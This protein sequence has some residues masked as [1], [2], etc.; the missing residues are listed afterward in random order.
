MSHH[1]VYVAP[2]VFLPPPTPISDPNFSPSSLSYKQI[3]QETIN[4]RSYS[5][6][7]TRLRLSWSDKTVLPSRFLIIYKDQNSNKLEMHSYLSDLCKWILN[8]S[9]LPDQSVIYLSGPMSDYH[10]DFISPDLRGKI[11]FYDCKNSSN[12][13]LI[14]ALPPPEVDLIITVGGDGTILNA[15]W[16]Y[17]KT[18]PPILSFHCGTLGFLTEFEPEDY[19][20][21][22][23]NIFGSEGTLLCMRMRLECQFIKGNE[24]NVKEKEAMS[25][26]KDDKFLIFDNLE[27]DNQMTIG[28]GAEERSRGMPL[29]SSFQTCTWQVLNELTIDRGSPFMGSIDIYGDG[30]LLTTVLGDGLIIA[31]PTGSTAYSVSIMH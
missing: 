2:G 1:S 6:N 13:I 22:L 20:G 23:D 30:Q 28:N 31:T 8:H 9:L 29:T 4:I 18:V 26:E 12:D 17:Q 16:L 11:Q 7:L 24:E 25:N 3:A 27:K 19:S 5:T 14:M 10:C 21:I 15:A